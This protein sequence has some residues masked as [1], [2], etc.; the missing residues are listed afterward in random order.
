MQGEDNDE[1]EANTRS[2]A[3]GPLSTE[4]IKAKSPVDAPMQTQGILF[5][6]QLILRLERRVGDA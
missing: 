6:N 2:A 3:C 1:G 4:G 5:C